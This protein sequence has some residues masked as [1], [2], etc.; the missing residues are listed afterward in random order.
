DSLIYASR[1]VVIDRNDLVAKADSAFLDGRANAETMH[2]MYKP[3]VEGREGRKFKLEGDVIDA[4]SKDRKLQRVVARAKAH[5]LSQDLDLVADTIDLRM[6]NDA[7]ERA[8]AWSKSGQAKATA[9][10]QAITAD[11]IDA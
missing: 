11:S 3:T 10:G 2:L 5:A 7:M 4:Y 8:I 1:S 9:P 6:S